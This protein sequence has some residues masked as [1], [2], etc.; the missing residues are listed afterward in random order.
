[1]S[2]EEKARLKAVKARKDAED[3][4]RQAERL[5]D[6][7]ERRY[8]IR[9]EEKQRF[10][11]QQ[12]QWWDEEAKH[13]A[14]G[15]DADYMAERLGR[16]AASSHETLV[17]TQTKMIARKERAE[18]IQME[19][20][21]ADLELQERR[22]REQ[23]ALYLR[24]TTI[25]NQRQQTEAMRQANL[26]AQHELAEE[27]QK[28]VASQ[29]QAEQEKFKLGEE[30]RKKREQERQEREL[31]LINSKMK[32]EEHKQ[33]LFM[34]DEAARATLKQH[35]QSIASTK[36]QQGKKKMKEQV[37]ED[38]KAEAEAK[39]KKDAD[40]RAFH[41]QHRKKQAEATLMIEK[42]KRL[43]EEKAVEETLKAV[44]I[45]KEEAEHAKARAAMA[46]GDL[47]KKKKSTTSSSTASQ[48]AMRTAYENKMRGTFGT[49]DAD[50]V[51]GML[52]IW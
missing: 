41:Q 3:A 13:R 32:A 31:N 21:H 34:R 28:L 9:Q 39:K 38:L 24:D 36:L 15:N 26:R 14:Q 43:A 5:K 17:E 23:D 12:R 10:T 1:M 33:S 48:V 30:E 2:L 19:H 22:R 8:R 45:A 25:E 6:D 44:E 52:K 16:S 7:Q 35:K 20:F 27:T 50:P 29:S 47:K 11:D 42:N 18:K 51:T 40:R 49:G 37:N 4:R 46:S